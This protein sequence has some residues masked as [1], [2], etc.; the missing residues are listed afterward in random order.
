MQ[1]QVSQCLSTE[2]ESFCMTLKRAQSGDHQSLLSI[3]DFLHP[4]MQYLASFIKLPREESI[5]AMKAAM[6]E[7]IRHGEIHV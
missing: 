2:N 4:D 3:L 7:A 5:Q 1:K 6:L